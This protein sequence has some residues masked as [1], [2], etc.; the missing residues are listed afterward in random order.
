MKRNI[1]LYFD[2]I[3]QNIK[4][5]EAST[6]SLTQQEFNDNID[7]QDAFIRRIEIIGEAVK[8]T[9]QEIKDKNPDIPW[10]KIAGTRDIF[11]HNY[12]E[13]NLDQL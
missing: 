13:V 6:Q 3:L 1:G 10:K 8:Q 5:I 4:R 11:I 12:M 7:I 2:D 9:P